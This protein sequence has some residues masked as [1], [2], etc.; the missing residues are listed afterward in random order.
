MTK[1]ISI[2]KN[3]KPKKIV[4]KKPASKNKTTAK[5]NIVQ[6]K[7]SKEGQSQ[8][9]S[10]IFNIG[11]NTPK[12][13]SAPIR[14]PVKPAQSIS[15]PIIQSYNQPIFKPPI[16]QQSS[17]ASSILATQLTPKVVAEEVKEQTSLR[18]ALQEQ[19]TDESTP[20]V[21]DLERVRG[22]R[23][24]KFEKPVEVKKEMD[25][26]ELYRIALLSQSLADQQ[27]DTEEIQALTIR[28][29]KPDIPF[30]SSVEPKD[31]PSFITPAKTTS[32]Y[33]NALRGFGLDSVV[34]SR[35]LLTKS[36]QRKSLLDFQKFEAEREQ[37][38]Q[39]NIHENAKR[40]A[41]INIREESQ[42]EAYFDP[43]EEPTQEEEAPLKQPEPRGAAELV[44][45]TE[46]TEPQPLTQATAELGFG[47]LTEEP[48]HTSVGQFLPP[49][50]VSQNELATK[51]RNIKLPSLLKPVE[52]PP[53]I[54]EPQE[55]APTILQG[56][57]ATEVRAPDQYVTEQLVKDEPQGGAPLAE[58]EV[59]ESK[60]KIPSQGI[61]IEAKW[62]QL[63]LEKKF[64]KGM[65]KGYKGISGS[66]KLDNELLQDILAV[67]GEED[68]KPLEP[69]TKK[70][71]R[72]NV[73][74][75]E[76]IQVIEL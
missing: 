1:G 28:P 76:E 50:P 32:K 65:I 36:G 12:K 60:Q 45:Q 20:K 59:I 29:T 35:E 53:Q 54:T 72:R 15:Q 52:P 6:N 17:L 23:I 70:G 38:I 44:T 61:Q 27:D 10:I 69:T 3:V 25:K 2:K 47:G 21:N 48:I 43:F 33:V 8:E 31:T 46:T 42:R 34:P 5:R 22:E 51:G 24:K 75:A 63:K 39:K 68:W 9:Q 18:K 14:K 7:P 74:V 19:N 73:V 58:A 57:Q 41:D 4:S 64:P 26:E 67:S 62:D 55:T 16:P 71:R 66:R 56:V 11:T 40:Q 30:I 37:R 13:R 49:E